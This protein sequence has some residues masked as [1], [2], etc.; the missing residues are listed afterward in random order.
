M[1]K[2]DKQ[3]LI[4]LFAI[5]L[6]IF[7]MLALRFWLERTRYAIDEVTLCPID[8][9]LSGHTAILVDRTDALSNEQSRALRQLVE[10]LGSSIRRAEKLSILAITSDAQNSLQR[11]FSLCSPGGEIDA[12]PLYQNPKRMQRRFQE[13]FGRPLD[14]VISDLQSASSSDYSP[15]IETVNALTREQDFKPGILDRKLIIVSDMLQ[16]TRGYSHYNR[17]SDVLSIAEREYVRRHK[18][19]LNGVNV[20]V[21]LIVRPRLAYRQG[22][23]HKEFWQRYFTEAGASSIKIDRLL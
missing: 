11:L 5:A 14:E 16:N 4:I 17:R 10:S 18:P 1:S 19:A 13:S 21:R 8:A 23:N 12:N 9:P 2:A 20:T 15:I 22:P 3:G 7:L 6:F